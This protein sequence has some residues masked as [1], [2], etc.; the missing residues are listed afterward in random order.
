M[1]RDNYVA[2]MLALDPKTQR[3]FGQ[4]IKQRTGGGGGLPVGK[5]PSFGR[6]RKTANQE[7]R[8]RMILADE[9]GA[10]STE[11]N[12]ERILLGRGL[13]HA[14]FV[15]T[16]KFMKGIVENGSLLPDGTPFS[17]I[18]PKTLF[19]TEKKLQKF[20]DELAASG[21][22]KDVLEVIRKVRNKKGVT[23][24]VIDGAYLL[25]KVVVDYVKKSEKVMS[26]DDD[27]GKFFEY[28][29][30]LTSVWRGLATL[31]PGFHNRN[32]LG[33]LWTNHMAGVGSKV[34]TNLS[35]FGLGDNA[36][37]VP[38]GG[39]F[40]LRHLEAMKLQVMTN[41]AGK[42]P[43]H[44]KTAMDAASQHIGFGD[45]KS[46]P[47]PDIMVEGKMYDAAGIMRLA[48]EHDVPQSVT[49]ISGL[50]EEATKVAFR[51][52]GKTI[53]LS[54]LRG[55]GVNPLTEAAFTIEANKRSSLSEVTDRVVGNGSP[56]LQANRAIA[57]I[58]ENNGRLAL[59]I[60]R[61]M[62][63]DSPDI[64]AKATKTW[65]FDY[66]KLSN[67]E[68]QIFAQAL[69]FYAWMRFSTPRMVMALLENPGR[70]AKTPKLKRAL[71]EY[72]KRNGSPQDLP[73]PD[74]Y[75]ETQAFQL[76]AMYKDNYPL[77]AQLDLPLMQLNQLNTADLGG[78][79]HPF[80]KLLIETATGQNLFLD[81]PIEKFPGEVSEDLALGG[82]NISKES[83]HVIG[84]LLPPVE[85]YV[86]RPTEQRQRQRL[87]IEAVRQSGITFRALDVRRVLRGKDYQNAALARAFEK[88]IKQDA[89]IARKKALR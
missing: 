34:V 72:N 5:T 35:K 65:H 36:I 21:S 79:I 51:D 69:P 85:R 59:F 73:V 30:K 15:N 88:K 38:S 25:P 9:I 22:D 7:E 29:E 45:F 63:G 23:E 18:I 11:L 54:Q 50:A 41:G 26:N 33:M 6:P 32:Y 28:A 40:A 56:Q 80:G 86:F 89:E 76:P 70:V 67:I 52:Q 64:A 55:A 68:K 2:G 74:Y 81:T 43:S 66:R 37:T 14:R 57:T 49:K 1:F 27:L 60:D 16:R 10:K 78:S 53:P 47:F 48:Q 39:G 77:F 61:L 84:T 42:L 46:V 8:L 31:S 71:E 83:R 44:L 87:D 24:N 20:K 58:P 62:K 13:E 4:F 3:S 12:I 75:E 17:Q 82:I 19:K